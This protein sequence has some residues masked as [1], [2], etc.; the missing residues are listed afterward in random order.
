MANRD[1]PVNGKRSE[2]LL[3]ES[4]N[5]ILTD[6]GEA[7]AW[8]TD[9]ISRYP[10]ELRLH[11]TGNLVLQNIEGDVIW[12]SFDSPTDTLLPSQP[13]T[14]YT[15]L[16]ASRSHTNFS[17]GFYKLIF[18]DKN[19][20]RLLY[21]GPEVS[22]VYWPYPWYKDWEGGRSPYN[23]S[24]IASL[25]SLGKF[26][27]SDHFSFLS[28]D[29]GVSLQRRLTLD[30]DGNARLYSREEGSARWAVSWQAKSQV[31]EIHGICGPNST[32]SYNPLSGSKCSC[33]PGYKMKKTGDWSYGCEPKFNLSCSNHAEI[34]F[35]Q[36][37][38][39][40]FYGHDGNFYSNVSLETCKKLCLESCNCQGFQYR[41]I[42]DTIVPYCYPKMLLS[43]GQYTP[44]FG[45]DFYIKVPKTSLFSG[46][47]EASG[48]GLGICPSDHAKPLS[49]FRVYAGSPENGTLKF[50][51]LFAY[52]VG[53]VEII[54]I[55]L[56]CGEIE[57]ER[58]VT[59]VRDKKNKAN[60]VT[61]WI[62]EIID[63]TL[64]GKYDQAKMEALIS[65]ALQ[66]VEEDKDARPTMSRVVEMLLHLE[67]DN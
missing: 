41:H 13:L 11:D 43:N 64:E 4:G 63:P 67:N 24:R 58:L 20:L 32:C 17:S 9:T 37:K 21:E 54:V 15:E 29:W 12:Q 48:L 19:L 22:S 60:G 62:E 65:L 53:G 30:S 27:S 46:N 59:L 49:L 45:G 10:A 14:K 57:H 36:L 34:G 16:V 18:D 66:C 1:F 40:E 28:S 33:L 35:I 55:L 42:G 5:L 23:S 8:S 50:M 44:S 47:E 52:G 56:A 39:V 26:T 38:H 51:L 7:T 3:L 6:A 2:L 25:D 61:S 31:C